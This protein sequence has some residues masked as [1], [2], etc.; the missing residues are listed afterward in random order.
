MAA[1]SSSK[2]GVG[3]AGCQA[4]PQL[5]KAKVGTIKKSASIKIAAA[6]SVAP[7]AESPAESWDDELAGCGLLLEKV[8]EDVFVKKV[9]P[10]GAAHDDGRILRGDQ[11]THVDR[12]TTAELPLE[13]VREHTSAPL[14]CPG[15]WLSWALAG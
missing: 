4:M 14:S 3:R 1:Y 11:V 5:V 9:V 13:E 7:P 8:D 6:A 15:R 12:A 10:G 2:A